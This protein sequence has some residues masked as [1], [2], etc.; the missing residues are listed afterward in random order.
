MYTHK[1][2]LKTILP[3]SR[4]IPSTEPTSSTLFVDFCCGRST[5]VSVDR[6]SLCISCDCGP[7]VEQTVELCDGVVTA[8]NIQKTSQ[9][10][11]QTLDLRLYSLAETTWEQLRLRLRS[12]IYIFIHANYFPSYFTSQQID[13]SKGTTVKGV[14]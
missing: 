13:T 2:L 14:I 4:L 5:D 7:D 9:D 3:V 12:C 10:C 1:L 8:A 6:R 11:T